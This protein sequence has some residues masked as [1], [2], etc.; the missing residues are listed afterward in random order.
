MI[1]TL[2]VYVGAPVICEFYLFVCLLFFCVYIYEQ[3]A[4]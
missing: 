4:A 2:K 3:H 1:C